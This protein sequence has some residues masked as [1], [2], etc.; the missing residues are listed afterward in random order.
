MSGAKVTTTHYVEFYYP[1][2]FFPETEVLE[3]KSR[4][5][6]IDIP[7]NCFGYLFFDIKSTGTG[8]NKMTTDR[9][10]ETPMTYFGKRYTLAQIKKQFPKERILISNMSQYKPAVAVRTRCGNWRPLLE[11]ET[12]IPADLLTS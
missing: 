3:I 1:G 12:V 9:L 5:Q 6:K 2:V 8:K 11:G 4:K 7:S 10:N